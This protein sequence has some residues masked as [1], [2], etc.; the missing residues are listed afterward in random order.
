MSGVE[1]A[2][3]LMEKVFCKFGFL[4]DIV[5]HRDT[6]CTSGFYRELCRKLGIHLS[7]SSAWHPE[8]DGNTEVVNKVVETTIRAHF[9]HMQTNW[10]ELLCMVEFAINNSKHSFTRFTPF[11][12]KFGR[13]ALTPLART[14]LPLQEFGLYMPGVEFCPSKWKMSRSLQFTI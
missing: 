9:N 3:L 13:H 2:K 10:G 14:V 1:V 11:F 8:S 12:M 6:R 5:S 7:M 4:G